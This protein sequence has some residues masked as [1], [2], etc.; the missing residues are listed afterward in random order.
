MK[1]GTTQTCPPIE[2]PNIDHPIG[3]LDQR[4]NVIRFDREGAESVVI[5]NYGLHADTVNGD[6]VSSDWCGWT[7]RT[8]EK[9]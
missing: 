8:I 7:R 1:D 3:T 9:F 6:M 2:D 4:V 5:L